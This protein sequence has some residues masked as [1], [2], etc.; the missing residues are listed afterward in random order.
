MTDITGSEWQIMR[1]IWAYERLTSAD[2]IKNLSP[3]SWKPNSICT[4]LSRLV[5]K[6]YLHNKE[7]GEKL[8]LLC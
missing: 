4:L 1:A 7:E 8:P 2:I 3:R 6:G 5:S